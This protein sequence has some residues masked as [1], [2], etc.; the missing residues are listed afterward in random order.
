MG[1]E[2][3]QFDLLVAAEIGDRIKE[4]IEETKGSTG[5]KNAKRAVAKRNQRKKE[6]ISSE[7]MGNIMKD[8]VGE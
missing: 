1:Y 7:T 4:Q 3:L 5:S 8:F 6:T 2:L